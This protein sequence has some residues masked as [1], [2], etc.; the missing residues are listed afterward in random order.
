MLSDDEDHEVADM[1]VAGEAANF[2]EVTNDEQHDKSKEVMEEKMCA[3]WEND[4][5]QLVP[6][7]RTNKM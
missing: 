4:T 2:A 5:W 6:P 1:I 7:Q 3:L